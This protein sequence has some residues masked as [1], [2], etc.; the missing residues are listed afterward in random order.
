MRKTVYISIFILVF[1]GIA[2][3]QICGQL[4][5]YDYE[6]P[7]GKVSLEG[8]SKF[9]K[10]DFDGNFEIQK[11][12]NTEKVNLVIDLANWP[13]NENFVALKIIIKNLEL[14]ELTKIDLGKIHLP[15]YKSISISEFEQ[16][17]ESEKESCIA[18]YHWAQLNGYLYTNK[19]ENEYLTLNCKDKITDFEFNLTTKTITVDWKTIKKCE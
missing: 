8:Q 15:D 19:L 18:T 14:T 2:N 1:S 13:V 4:F 9:V 10:T 11:P 7:V 3:A 6:Y 16:L 17:S 5:Q 12:S